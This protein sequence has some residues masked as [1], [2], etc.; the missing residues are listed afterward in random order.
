M[1]A[2]LLPVPFAFEHDAAARRLRV[3][4]G[5]SMAEAE[6]RAQYR[7]LLATA[8]AARCRFWLLDLRARNWH[9][10]SFGRWF[11]EE[12]APQVHAALHGSAFL[13]YVL[14]PALHGAVSS[15]NAQATQCG[16]AE[17][18]VYPFFFDSE[19]AAVA[20]LQHQQSLDALPA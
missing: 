7:A 20:W 9:T 18:D 12:F 3:A 13:A 8:A 4:W 14:D 17:H 5:S 19:L 16:C 2:D 15:P 1:P 11:S 6:M 10:V